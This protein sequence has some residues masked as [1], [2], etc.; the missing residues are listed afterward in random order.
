M[1]IKDFAGSIKWQVDNPI[2]Q[3]KV[4]EYQ[5]GNGGRYVIMFAKIPV[6]ACEGIGCSEDSWLV[7]LPDGVKQGQCAILKSSGYLDP[8][9]V[10]EKFRLDNNND[11][12]VLT[13]IIGHVLNRQ[14]PSALD[15]E[16]YKEW[17]VDKIH[18]D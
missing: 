1:R 15:E 17:L 8:S 14:T 9:Y 13:E 3:C 5:P 12:L 6:T 7:S 11:A 16:G 2:P 18:E 4:L 10:K